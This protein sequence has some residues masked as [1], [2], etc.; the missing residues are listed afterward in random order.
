MQGN[1]MESRSNGSDWMGLDPQK[2]RLVSV[3]DVCMAKAKICLGC[4]GTAMNRARSQKMGVASTGIAM[5]M[6]SKLTQKK[7]Y[8][9]ETLSREAMEKHRNGSGSNRIVWKISDKQWN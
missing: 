5:A 1:G 4:K 6:W 2:R 3:S 7:S 9:C 8:E